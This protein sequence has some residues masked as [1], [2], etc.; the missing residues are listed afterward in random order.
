M[1]YRK[2]RSKRRRS[3]RSIR[4][5]ESVVTYRKPLDMEMTSAASSTTVVSTLSLLPGD[6]VRSTTNR[7]VVG[8]R[9][10]LAFSAKLSASETLVALFGLLAHPK[11]EDFPSIAEYDPF[12]ED[13][14]LAGSATY[15]GRPSPRPFARRYFALTN[16]SDGAEQTLTE[17]W[18][19]KSRAGRLLR[20]GWELHAG[21]WLWSNAAGKKARVGGSLAF[22]VSG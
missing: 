17:R 18:V 12:H 9:G 11:L 13:G 14:P 20:P 1:A 7:K 6:T 22:T 10:S 21:I 16:V 5:S 8:A 15:E 2:R 3:R 4:P 19:M